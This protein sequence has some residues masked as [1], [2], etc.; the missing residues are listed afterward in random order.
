MRK[1]CLSRRSKSL[2]LGAAVA[3][4]MIVI[5]ASGHA[6][7]P[8]HSAQ[9]GTH[10]AAPSP[11]IPASPHIV[12]AQQDLAGLIGTWALQWEGARDKYTGT[13]E[14]TQQAGDNLYV[15]LLRLNPSKGG[16]VQEDARISST[17]VEIRIECSNP[18]VSGR[19][20][21][22]S[23]NPDRFFVV[24]DGNRMEGYSLDS[25]G[26]RGPKISFKKTQ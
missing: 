19:S 4:V 3:S 15:G 17:G 26:Q 12:I 20:D 8:T 9:I 21:L 25:A 7:S 1:F 16:M 14:V 23:W 5:G 6:S 11:G 24:R 13:L 10:G 2:V 22:T 18:K